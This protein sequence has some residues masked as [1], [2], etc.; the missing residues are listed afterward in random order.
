VQFRRRALVLAEFGE[1]KG[2]IGQEMT[3]S[4]RTHG[5]VILVGEHGVVRG[6]E[7]LVLPLRS[8]SLE[9]SWE[10]SPDG[11]YHVNS[12]LTGE[13]S[14]K[15]GP[16]A[17][18]FRDALNRALDLT[19]FQT[20]H[21]GY[22]IA[23]KS[24]IPVRAGLGSSAALS[25]AVVR[26]LAGEGA[27]LNQPFGLAL[28]I[29]NLFHGTSS[30]I[31]V[32]CVLSSAPIRYVR[33]SPPQDL[34][35]A[36]KPKLYLYDTGLRAGTKECVE[37]VAAAKRSDLDARMS[38]SVKA[39]KSALLSEQGDRM[40]LLAEALNLA[41]TCFEEWGLGADPELVSRLRS[42]GALAVKPTGSGGGGFLLSL[43]ENAPPEG[44]SLIPVWEDSS[45]VL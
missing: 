23:I 16:L 28:E 33:S 43:W 24:D 30:G 39:A 37:K 29:E 14:H 21:R 4:T 31:D 44:L 45:K 13:G 1:I 38:E 18:P 17:V 42:L 20:P 27:Q 40:A 8:R 12:A 25:V 36:W 41:G 10:P 15:P 19:Q 34:R 6:N 11:K 7:A 3:S 32:A 5:K 26:F 9:L 22:R 2:G 35:M